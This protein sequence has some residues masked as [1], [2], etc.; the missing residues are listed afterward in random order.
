[1]IISVAGDTFTIHVEFLTSVV[2]N[3][4]SE[5]MPSVV[6]IFMPGVSLPAC[7]LP[8]SDVWFTVSETDFSIPSSSSVNGDNFEHTDGF[9]AGSEPEADIKVPVWESVDSSTIPVHPSI[10]EAHNFV[11]VAISSDG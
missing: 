4:K 3:S 5:V 7:T 10:C 8:D 6:I 11:S 1:V 9:L 2:H